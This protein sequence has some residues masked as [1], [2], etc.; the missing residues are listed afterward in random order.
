MAVA[1]GKEAEGETLTAFANSRRPAPGRAVTTDASHRGAQAALI[2][3]RRVLR[4]EQKPQQG[5]EEA[6]AKNSRP[7]KG[8]WEWGLLKPQHAKGLG[9]T[10]CWQAFERGALPCL[11]ALASFPSPVHS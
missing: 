11:P 8:R 5:P 2:A 7:R 3:A 1:Q 4:F 10:G 9:L 6:K